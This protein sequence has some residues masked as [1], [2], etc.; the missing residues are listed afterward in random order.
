MMVCE[1][2]GGLTG[3]H[4]RTRGRHGPLG[5]RQTYPCGNILVALDSPT[6]PLV[7]ISPSWRIWKRDTTDAWF[8]SQTLIG[9]VKT[10][11]SGEFS[12]LV[13]GD[14]TSLTETA[15]RFVEGE[16][17]TGC[18]VGM[19]RRTRQTRLA[20]TAG[21]SNSLLTAG[22]YNLS[23]RARDNNMIMAVPNRYVQRY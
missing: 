18:H 11:T 15:H 12:G 17:I 22:H 20:A 4:W 10:H 23:L 6:G 21:I 16:R 5:H 9:A 1:D 2:L 14:R 19:H 3:S 13:K 7:C 8:W